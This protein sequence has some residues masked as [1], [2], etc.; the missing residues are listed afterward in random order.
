[1]TTPGC[2]QRHPVEVYTA[3][4]KSTTT[5]LNLSKP[6]NFKTHA[7]RTKRKNQYG[8]WATDTVGGKLIASLKMAILKRENTS[9]ISSTYVTGPDERDTMLHKQKD[10]LAP[11]SRLL[12]TDCPAVRFTFI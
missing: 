12:I 3:Q 4:W 2:N 5:N 7:S 10:N 1:M 6:Y 9:R 11:S 8:Q